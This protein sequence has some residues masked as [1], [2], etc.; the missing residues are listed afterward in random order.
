[1]LDQVLKQELKE[2]KEQQK[3]LRKQK[4][5]EVLLLK[6]Q[7]KQELI[8]NNIIVDDKEFISYHTRFKALIN[9]SIDNNVPFTISFSDYVKL[10]KQTTCYICNRQVNETY[11]IKIIMQDGYTLANYVPTCNYC[12]PTVLN[13]TNDYLEWL[14]VIYSKLIVK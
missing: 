6:E 3:Q 10:R 8:N 12:S 14:K 11:P 5:E 9:K 4:Q 1:M 2:Y 13:P 7:R